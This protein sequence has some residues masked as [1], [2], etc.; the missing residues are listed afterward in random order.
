MRKLRV[1]SVGCGPRGDAHMAAMRN[2]GA[3]DLVAACDL[4]AP[5]LHALAAKHFVASVYHDLSEMIG[6]EKPDLVDIVTPPTLRVPVVEAAIAAGAK[7]ILIEKPIALR[8]SEGRR[9]VEL[10]RQSG[11]FV[12]VNTQYQWMPHWRRFWRLIADG[13]LGD[14]RTIRCST[15]TNL[16]EQGPHVLDLAARA[17][18]AGGLPQPEWV[19]AATAGVERFGDVPVPADTAATV[20]LGPARLFWNQGPSAPHVPGESNGWFHIQVEVV[21]SAGR[22]W[23][24]LNRGWELWLDG[25]FER[26][27]TAWPRDDAIAQAAMFQELRDRIDDGT[28][29]QFPTRIEVAARHSD[30]TFAC[31]ASALGNGRVKLPAKVDDWVV[32]QLNVLGTLSALEA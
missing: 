7:N 19:L 5:R 9:L 18:E 25:R 1:V 10:S 14:V 16:L 21:G 15:R 17:A 3:A 29:D 27:D 30:L 12:A 20:G 4:D 22:L 11:C 24:S 23:V 28:T 13:R 2:S 26:G 32:D 6:R 8:P 31:Y